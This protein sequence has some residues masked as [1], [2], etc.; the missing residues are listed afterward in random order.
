MK[1]KIV[2]VFLTAALAASMLAGCGNSDSG[3]AKSSST[4]SASGAEDTASVL[5]DGKDTE[6][7]IVFPGSSSSPA[8]LTEVEDGINKIISEKIDAHVKLDIL[9]W[10]VFSE[11]ENLMLS[12]GEDVD[13]VFLVGNVATS[14][15]SGQIMDISSYMDTYGKDAEETMG[16]YIKACYIGD[17]LYGLPT[18]HEYA[19][20]GGLVCNADLFAETGFTEDDVKTWDDVEKVLDKVKELYPNMDVLVPPEAKGGMLKYYWGGVFDQIVSNMVGVYNEG[21]DGT[22]VHNIYDTDEFRELAEKAYEWNQKG[23]FI[24]DA[25]TITETRQTLLKTGNVFGYIGGIHPGTKTQEMTNAG[26]N[27]TTLPITEQGCGTNNV[28]GSQYCVAASTDS[29]EKSVAVLNEIYS[30]AD[31]QNLLRYGIE[32]KDYEMKS[33]NVAGYPEGVDGST[34]GWV[35]ETWLTGNASLAYAWETDPEDIWDEYKEYNDGAQFSPAYGFSYDSSNVKTE[36]TAVQNVLDKYT[37]TIY[38]GM[39]DPTTTVDAFNKELESAGINVI[40][41]DVQKQLDDW[42]AAQK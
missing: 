37:A 20:R 8:S 10:G 13:I 11:Q 38:S 28:A 29:V 42:S 40:I 32:G 33:D 9:E 39:S 6:I 1:R 17:A 24:A 2:S 21:S 16:Q 12:S 3:S 22:T 35:N 36:I 31:I 19:Q 27:I 34:A 4:A 26:I 41:E 18:Y 30:N 15:A 25:N 14:A 23:Y 7:R 5:K